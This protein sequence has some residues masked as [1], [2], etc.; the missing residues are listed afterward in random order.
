M[1]VV[2]M[3]SSGR[4]TGKGVDGGQTDTNHG[5]WWANRLAGAV[6]VTAGVS[7][8]SCC[9]HVL[10]SLTGA[11]MPRE[12]QWT[13]VPKRQALNRITFNLCARV[14]GPSSD[15]QGQQAF[16]VTANARPVQT[17]VDSGNGCMLSTTGAQL[18]V[19]VAVLLE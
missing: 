4:Y 2:L 13:T 3:C 17:L 12:P 11:I 8:R 1:S 5:G 19:W 6:V 15:L 16:Y 14:S 10:P 18:G 7:V 9:C